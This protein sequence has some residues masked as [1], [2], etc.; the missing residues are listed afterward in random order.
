ML[1]PPEKYAQINPVLQYFAHS[2]RFG[3]HIGC[4][5]LNANNSLQHE[6]AK[7]NLAYQ[8]VKQNKPFLTEAI[9][10]SRRGIADFV[11]LEDRLIIE[12]LHTET[13]E[14]FLEKIK[15]YPKFFRI[16]RVVV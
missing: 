7:F 10:D 11:S 16:K 2:N 4:V 8:A 12:I 3:S 1:I 13:K 6:L 15:D 9:L 14:A 5:R